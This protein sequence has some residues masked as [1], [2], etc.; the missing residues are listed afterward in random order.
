MSHNRNNK[1]AMVEEVIN[2]FLFLQQRKQTLGNEQFL[3]FRLLVAKILF[4]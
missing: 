1:R 4:K 3:D 2:D